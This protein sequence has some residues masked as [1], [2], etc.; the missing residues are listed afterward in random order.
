[1]GAYTARQ[2]HERKMLSVPNWHLVLYKPSPVP[3]VDQSPP[4]TARYGIANVWTVHMLETQVHVY[5][6]R[7]IRKVLRSV[8]RQLVTGNPRM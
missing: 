8:I 6:Y 2:R 4:K 3:S 1:V 5:Y 7:H